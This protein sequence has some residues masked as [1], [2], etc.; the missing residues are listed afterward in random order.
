MRAALANAARR[1]DQTS[2]DI[3]RKLLTEFLRSEGLMK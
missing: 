1:H 3:V 2:S